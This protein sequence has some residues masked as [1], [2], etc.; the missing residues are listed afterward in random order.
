VWL[1]SSYAMNTRRV[2]P[3]LKKGQTVNARYGS[4]SSGGL[5]EP[6]QQGHQAPLSAAESTLAR[7]TWRGGDGTLSKLK[8]VT[9]GQSKR[10]VQK[11]PATWM[12][13]E[14]LPAVASSFEEVTNNSDSS[15]LTHPLSSR[16]GC[17]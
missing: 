1:R 10:Q 8:P 12:V 4:S 15:F 16:Q 14:N 11:V 13:K 2:E 9:T 6:K 7:D 3:T 17:C 5:V